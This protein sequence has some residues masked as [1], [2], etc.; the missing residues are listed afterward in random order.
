MA[1]E[2]WDHLTHV[3]INRVSSTFMPK[4]DAEP[5]LSSFAVGEVLGQLFCL[6]RLR[7]EEA[8]AL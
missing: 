3:S 1:D 2:R 7:D 6:P 4:Q 8:M 5:V